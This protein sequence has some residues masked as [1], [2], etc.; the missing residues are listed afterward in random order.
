MCDPVLALLKDLAMEAKDLADSVH[1]GRPEEAMRRA[2][3]V[4]VLWQLL[5]DEVHGRG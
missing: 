2:R 3:K 5:A 1:G 4:L